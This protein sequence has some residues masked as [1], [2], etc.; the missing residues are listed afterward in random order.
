M[1]GTGAA[2]NDPAPAPP[3]NKLTFSYYDFSSGKEGV[4]INLRHTFKS[5]TAW[6]GGYRENSGF[7]QARVG[8]QYDYHHNWLTFTHQS[9]HQTEVP[10]WSAPTQCK[11][12][13]RKFATRSSDSGA[14]ASIMPSR[15]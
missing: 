7:D 11:T 6:I 1:N 13:D 12:L 2:A 3:P 4:D 8:Y 9:D 14:P 15:I 5:S 10:S